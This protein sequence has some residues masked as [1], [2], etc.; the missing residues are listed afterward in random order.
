MERASDAA[1]GGGQEAAVTGSGE[2][3]GETTPDDEED[4]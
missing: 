3:D 2:V 1:G 4:L